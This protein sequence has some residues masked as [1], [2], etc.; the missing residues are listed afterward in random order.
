[1]SQITQTLWKI[2]SLTSVKTL[3]VTELL[4]ATVPRVQE[5]HGDRR[6]PADLPDHQGEMEQRN[7]EISIQV[8]S[9]RYFIM[10]LDYFYNCNSH[11][12]PLHSPPVH[13]YRSQHHARN[14]REVL[15][16][17]GPQAHHHALHA[18]GQG[19]AGSAMGQGDAEL[20]INILYFRPC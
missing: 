13:T 10:I 11:A 18:A 1:M 6:I 15:A 2:T 16:Y 7:Y 5:D 4:D 14:A 9:C 20:L 19:A 12:P 8:L 3:R 17:R